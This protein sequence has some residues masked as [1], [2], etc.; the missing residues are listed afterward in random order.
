MGAVKDLVDLVAKL[1]DSVQDR[2][3]AA[4]LREIQRMIGSIQSEHAALHEQRISLMTKNSELKQQIASLHRQ[5]AELK[6]K[7]A[8]ASS[9]LSSETEALL[10]VFFDEARELDVDFLSSALS[11]E[12]SV[13]EYHMDILQKN[14]M[15]SQTREK[16]QVMGITSQAGFSIMPKGREY[17]MKKST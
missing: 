9:E 11:L 8:Q 1:N 12:P 2:K 17:I 10:K 5:L 13:A 6:Q 7:P 15:I 14:K 4:E 16:T 3:F